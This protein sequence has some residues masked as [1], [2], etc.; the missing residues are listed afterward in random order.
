ME[1]LQEF[2]RELVHRF[3]ANIVL[4][5]DNSSWQT[6]PVPNCWDLILLKTLLK[7][8]SIHLYVNG[9]REHILKELH[10]SR[11]DQRLQSRT[12][13]GNGKHI[14]VAVTGKVYPIKVTSKAR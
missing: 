12:D 8:S 13:T 7:D 6:K 14:W 5:A 10:N 4:M 3:L 1:R 9:D 11:R 2:L